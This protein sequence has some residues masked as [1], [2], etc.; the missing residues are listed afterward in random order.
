MEENKQKHDCSIYKS[1]CLKLLEL[2]CTHGANDCGEVLDRRM[3]VR[4]GLIFDGQVSKSAMA[5]CNCSPGSLFTTLI[6]RHV[7]SVQP[8]CSSEI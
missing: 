1:K 4:E 2:R 8:F 3:R 5:I 7:K 6:A